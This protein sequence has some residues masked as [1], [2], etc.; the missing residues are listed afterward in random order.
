MAAGSEIYVF[1]L[2]D[3]NRRILRNVGNQQPNYMA[4]VTIYSNFRRILDH[5]VGSCL[6]RVRGVRYTHKT[7]DDHTRHNEKSS[8]MQVSHFRRIRGIA[9]T[10]C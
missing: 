6:F 9:K 2:V 8:K 5:L 1:Y 10:D 7:V 3:G 4:P